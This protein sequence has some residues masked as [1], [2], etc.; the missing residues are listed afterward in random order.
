MRLNLGLFCIAFIT[1]LLELSL[2]RVFDVIWYSNMAY[3]VITLAMF[4]LGAAGVYQA[5]WPFRGRDVS[6][7]L[8]VLA[9]F[10]GIFVL[11]V[12]PM[13][14]ALP[15]D[16]QQIFTK[17][18]DNIAGF[19]GLYLVIAVPFFISGLIFTII[20]G[21][22]AGKVQ[23]LYFWDLFG[24]ALGCLL[25]VPLLPSIGPGGILFVISAIAFGASALFSKNT[26]WRWAAAGATLLFLAIPFWHDGYFEFRDHMNKRGVAAAKHDG[27]IEKS[28]WDPVSRIDVIDQKIWK[29]LAYDGG[30]QSSY[31]YRFNGDFAHLRAILPTNK[32]NRHFGGSFVYASHFFRENT[33]P[34]V[35]IIGSAAGQEVKAALLFGARH[36]DAVELVGYVVKLGKED[37]AAYNGGIFNDPRVNAVVGEGRSFLRSTDDLY[38][39]IQI[40]SNHTSSSI[41]SGTGAMET[42]Y[43]QTSEAYQEYFSHLK[44]DGILQIN[45]HVY[46]KMISTAALAWKQ[47]GRAD[48]RRH[49]LVF[50]AKKHYADN[51][52]T[53]L[54]KMTPWTP[55]E[56]AWFNDFFHGGIITMMENPL[57]SRESFLPDEFYNGNIPDEMLDSMDYRAM[58]A[59]DDRPYFNFL[60][61]NLKYFPPEV[62]NHMDYSTAALLNRQMIN[63]K[64]PRDVIHLFVIG[65]AAFFFSVIFILAPI[66]MS[67]DRRKEASWKNKFSALAYFS[68]LGAGFI[69]F[70]LVFIQIYMKLIGY[71]LY[72]YST[73]VFIMLLA[74]ALGSYFSEKLRLLKRVRLGVPFIAILVCGLMMVFFQQDVFQIFL[75]WPMEARIVMACL[76][77]FPISFFLGMP[78]PLGILAL[79]NKPAGAV[80]WAWAMNGL[81]TMIGGTASVILSLFYGFQAT[82]L[83]AL[84]LYAA[85]WMFF[86]R[87]GDNTLEYS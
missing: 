15:F 42:T 71:P 35:L 2:M 79:Q 18:L 22:Y 27:R 34:D 78:F 67:K 4:C 30:S 17:H 74:A 82:L 9:M 57:D 40:F 43:L 7:I 56:V 23:T 62:Q 41:A 10:Q 85:A 52:P 47:M 77:L 64:I 39:I 50:Q 51:L 6:Q 19:L 49:V 38:D 1:M 16:F 28:R 24:A 75:R 45:H 87:F 3:M 66:L 72:T 31:I 32:I 70:E 73:V 76:M 53:L 20:C 63:K 61:K 84:A 29:H 46:P 69:I 21:R 37:Y 14:N 54:I 8:A 25:V 44:S 33:H 60:R 26:F 80:A 12:R 36:V 48:F 58:A 65:V 55:A 81:F 13:I 11:G 5:I 86:K 68:C 83:V 59:T